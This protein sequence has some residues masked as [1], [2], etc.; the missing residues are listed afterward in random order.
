VRVRN[1]HKKQRAAMLLALCTRA[2]KSNTIVFC[3]R[4]KEA[5]RLKVIF[6]LLGL[7]YVVCVFVVCLNENN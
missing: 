3:A 4:K 6:G 2:M 1:V 5:H 7:R